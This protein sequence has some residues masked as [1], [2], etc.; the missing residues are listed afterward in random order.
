MRVFTGADVSSTPSIEQSA[1]VSGRGCGRDRG[2]DF[3]GRGRGFIGSGRGLY[4]GRQSASEKGL[5]QASTVDAVNTSPRSVERNSVNLSGH[6]Y[7]SLTLL[8]CVALL[9]TIHPLPPLF[10]HLPQLY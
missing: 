5:R 7:L 8:L 1:M 3:G 2:H 6:N 10:L 9:R 4:E